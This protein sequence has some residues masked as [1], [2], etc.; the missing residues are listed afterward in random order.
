MSFSR[1]IHPIFLTDCVAG[2]NCHQSG[3]PAGGLDLQTDFPTFQTPN[4]TVPD[5]IQLQPYN[6]ILYLVLLGP[7]NGIPRMPLDRAPLADAQI[8]AI[9]TWIE[10]GAITT[11]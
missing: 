10:E 7:Y 1:D 6:S 8:K 4:R 3:D 9:R 11:N 2:G 5:V